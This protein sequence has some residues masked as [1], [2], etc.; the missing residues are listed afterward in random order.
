MPWSGFVGIVPAQESE[1]QVRCGLGLLIRFWTGLGSHILRHHGMLL[2]LLSGSI[3]VSDTFARIYSIHRVIT[4]LTEVLF[5]MS[6]V[7]RLTSEFHPVIVRGLAAPHPGM[8]M[9]TATPAQD[10]PS[11]IGHFNPRIV[12]KV[13]HGRLVLPI[14]VASAKLERSAWGADF[15]DMFRIAKFVLFNKQLM[16]L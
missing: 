11:R 10:F 2:A 5:A 8:I 6:V 14:I 9:S 7:P 1:L 13:D 12:G 16:V 3:F 4:Y 15:G